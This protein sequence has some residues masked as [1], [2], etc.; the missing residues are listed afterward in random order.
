MEIPEP[1]RESLEEI[2]GIEGIV[3]SL[4]PEENMKRLARL[5]QAL[6]DP[7]RVRILFILLRHPL[8]V[9]LIKEITS[10]PDSKLSYH[11][12]ILKSAGLITGEQEGNWI[13]YRTT[14]LSVMI[15]GMY[16]TNVVL[17]RSQ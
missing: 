17:E 9:C 12:G 14:G 2:G 15:L 10:V 8:C 3:S 16:S 13:I 7:L 11:L 5:S 4:P 6:S 1:I